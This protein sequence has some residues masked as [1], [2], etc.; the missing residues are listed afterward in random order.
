MKFD[1]AFS[2]KQVMVSELMPQGSI[3]QVWAIDALAKEHLLF[4]ISEDASLI[5]GRINYSMLFYPK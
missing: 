2:I 5:P 1:T 3:A 4:E